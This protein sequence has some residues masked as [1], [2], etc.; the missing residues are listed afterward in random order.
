MI[1]KNFKKLNKKELAIIKKI[2][3]LFDELKNSNVEW[4][5]YDGGGGGNLV[6]Y[7]YRKGI[8]ESNF[9]GEGIDFEQKFS[10]HCILLESNVVSSNTTVSSIVP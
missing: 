10:N 1:D 6:F 2:D 7:K 8:S 9:I 3:S 4:Y 5:N